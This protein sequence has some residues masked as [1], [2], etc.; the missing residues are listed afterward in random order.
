MKYLLVLYVP[1]KVVLIIEIRQILHLLEGGQT[2]RFFFFK[3]KP[4]T[5]SVTELKETSF[6]SLQ[7][8][9]LTQGKECKRSVKM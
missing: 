7:I 8:R 3:F 5:L 6:K 1:L 9:G 2:I 4:F